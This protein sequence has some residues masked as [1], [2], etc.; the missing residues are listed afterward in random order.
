MRIP[1]LVTEADLGGPQVHVLDL[2]RG[3]RDV[4][5]AAVG[6]GEGQSFPNPAK[7]AGAGIRRPSSR[8]SPVVTSQ[9]TSLP[10]V[11]ADSAVFVDPLDSDSI[12]DGIWR[13]LS[14]PGLRETLREKR[15]PASLLGSGAPARR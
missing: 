12:A 6:V 8:R 4:Q 9:G 10:E 2:L 1:Y 7:E 3:L 14:S 15:P 11:V 13:I 5:D